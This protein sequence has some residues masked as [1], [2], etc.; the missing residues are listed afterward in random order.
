MMSDYAMT[1]TYEIPA[2]EGRDKQSKTIVLDTID[3]STIDKSNDITTHPIVTGEMVADHSIKNPLSMNVTGS[4]SIKQGKAI[5]INSD[6]A[7]LGNVQELFEEIMD[8]AYICQLVKVQYVESS[9]SRQEGH[10]RFAIRKNMVLKSIQWTEKINSVGFDFN[11]TQVLIA[12][13]EEGEVNVDDAFLPNITEPETLNFT[14][15]LLD[16][17]MVDKMVIKTLIETGLITDGFL[18]VLGSM[19]ATSLVAIGVAVGIAFAVAAMI[20][21]IG[22]AAIGIAA[23][24]GA[25]VVVAVGIYKLFKRLINSTK[26]K[27]K[28]FQAYKNDKKTQKEVKRFC[29]F[30]GEIHKQLYQ[31]NDVLQVRKINTN[32]PQECML[33]IGSFY[34]IFTF[35]RNN[36][37]NSYSLTVTQPT[38]NGNQERAIVSD[39]KSALRGIDE[40]TDRNA[41]FR[42]DETAE[43]VYLMQVDEEG[44]NDSD[45]STYYIFIS[46]INMNDYTNLIQD[47]IKNALCY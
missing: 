27:I 21:G 34:Y 3:D 25:V 19:T 6:G 41:I 44:K 2:I 47:I 35:E 16:I 11:F 15:T 14:D 18:S 31:L 4:F 5:V 12:E 38:D 10:A 13:V 30:E 36:L 26:Y 1:L 23:L 32:E 40:C 8:N 45:L 9:N 42:A 20:P 37:N 33:T 28:Q 7:V 29:N 24:I 46:S 39:V 22:H 17:S 43:Y